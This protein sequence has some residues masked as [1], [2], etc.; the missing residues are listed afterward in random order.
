MDIVEA[1]VLV[2]G[3][4]SG[5]GRATAR[6]LSALGARV[7]ICGRDQKRLEAAA[8]EC[9]A[10]AIHAD[11]GDESQV[12]RL[13]QTVIHELDG[14]N[15][16]INNAGFGTF[17]PLIRLTSEEMSKV[18]RTNVIGAM[19][20]ARESA[21]HFI[22]QENG[23][24]INVASTAGSRGYANGT[25]YVASK[26]ALTGMTEC[27]RAELREHNIRVMQVNPSEV[28]TPFYETSGRGVRPDN[29]TKLQAD[30]IAGVIVSMLQLNDRGFITQT[31]V[32]ATNPKG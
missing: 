21:R 32:W 13:V 27:W 9:N 17:A 10:I 31:S 19:L 2:T 26:F 8:E 28:I 12:R 16:L 23:N 6:Q 4:S 1:K 30:D 15:V 14:Y 22:A 25:A 20:A 5:I 7:A 18:L 11:V 29:P 24:I 3:G